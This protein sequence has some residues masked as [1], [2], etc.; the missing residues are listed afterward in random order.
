MDTS[1]DIVTPATNFSLVSLAEA[2]L[3]LGIDASDTSGDALTTFMMETY[4]AVIATLCNRVFAKETV[5]ETFR[6]IDKTRLYL[7]RYPVD[8]DDITSVTLGDDTEVTDYVVDEPAGKLTRSLGWFNDPV[9]VEYS[10]GY[11]LPTDAPLAL[12]QAVL[13]LIQAQLAT[14]GGGGLTSTQSGGIRMIAHK[15]SR[16]MYYPQ[17]TTSSTSGSSGGVSASSSQRVVDSLIS[18]YVRHAV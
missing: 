15:D 12:K 14:S 7:S 6:Y 9:T 5:I 1:V 10:G 8:S 16:V 13:L 18:H 11:N 2:K 3:V 4:S 17:G